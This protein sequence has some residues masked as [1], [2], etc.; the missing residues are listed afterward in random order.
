MP[1]FSLRLI[2]SRP[3]FW[4]ELEPHV[5]KRVRSRIESLQESAMRVLVVE[6]ER[7]LAENVARSLR[8][9]AGY[10]V[11]VAGDGQEGLFMA[12]SNSYAVVLL[13][14]MLPQMDG[15]ELLG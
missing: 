1:H 4:T 10:A 12:E 6:D 9:S 14:I 15:M 13:D 3:S 7:R 5:P 8:E 2:V 11:D